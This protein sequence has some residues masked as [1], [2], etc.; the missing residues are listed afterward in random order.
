VNV[1]RTFRTTLLSQVA[2]ELLHWRVS[3]VTVN[4]FKDINFFK[5][6]VYK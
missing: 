6:L 2:K 4:T 1:F 3:S 5:M